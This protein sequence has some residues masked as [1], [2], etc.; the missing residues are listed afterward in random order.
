MIRN[1]LKDQF[2]NCMNVNKIPTYFLVRMEEQEEAKL[3]IKAIEW[4]DEVDK[5]AEKLYELQVQ[6]AE[7]VID[8]DIQF[9]SA[10]ELPLITWEQQMVL[11]KQ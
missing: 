11:E 3:Q 9:E 2:Y 10:S 1:I 6:E 7:Y 4:I 8:Q 5:A